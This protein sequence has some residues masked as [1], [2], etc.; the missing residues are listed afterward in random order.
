M[1]FGLA[2]TALRE[3][4]SATRAKWKD[5]KKF[6]FLTSSP[7]INAEQIDLHAANGCIRDEWMPSQS[8]MLANDWIII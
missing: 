1:D 4:K 7:A 5:Q 3:G 2:I 6:M 8:D